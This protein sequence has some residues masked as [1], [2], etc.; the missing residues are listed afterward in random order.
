M[1]D[2]SVEAA[3]RADYHRRETRVRG[4]DGR[5]LLAVYA[6]G[7]GTAVVEVANTCV[8][9]PHCRWALELP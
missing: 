7:E 1:G 8:A 4:A 2:G 3:L 5:D 9:F 6:L